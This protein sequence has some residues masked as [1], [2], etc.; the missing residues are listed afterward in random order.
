MEN[1]S[2]AAYKRL[3]SNPSDIVND[4]IVNSS[5]PTIIMDKNYKIIFVNELAVRLYGIPF[6]KIFMKNYFGVFCN[7]EDEY[8]EF[9]EFYA[10]IFKKKEPVF[11]SNKQNN[12]YVRI[13]PILSPNTGEVEYLHN[14]FI[15]DEYHMT[16]EQK[17]DLKLNNDYIQF[18]HQLS[19]LIEAKDKYTAN[20]SS[21]VAKYSALLGKSIGLSGIE[22]EKLKL[23]SSLHD[24]GKVSIP[25]HILNK[26]GK[27]NE[28]EYN[29]IKEHSNYSGRI[30]K[31]FK[32]LGDISDA[33]LYH[34]EMYNGQGYPY[35]IKGRDI[36]L[37]ARIIT[38]TD[39]FD[40]MTT[41]RPY[42]MAVSLNE[43]I[44][45]LKENRATQFD[46]YLVDKFVNLNLSEA[47]NSLNN[48][49]MMRDDE[50][51][52][53]DEVSKLMQQNIY[54]M[55]NNIDPFDI[56][57]NMINHNYYGFIISKDSKDTSENLDDRFE[58]L[59]KS[60]LVDELI[61]NGYLHGNWQM[62]LKEKKNDVCNNCPVDR[63]LSINSMHIKKSKLVNSAGNVKYLKTLLRPEHSKKNNETFILEL[64]KDETL[65]VIYGNNTA[66]EFFNFVDNLSKIFV[67]RDFEYS[68]IYGEIRGLANWIA[69][70]VLISEHK[71]ELLNKALSICDLGIVALLDSNEYIYEN[72]IS[73]RTNKEHIRII[74]NMI[75]NLRTFEDIKDIVL[76]HHIKYNDTKYPLSGDEVP[77]QSYIIGIAD[78]LLTYTVMGRPILEILEYLE[79]ASGITTS[80]LICTSI[81]QESSKN[82]LIEILENV[83]IK[84]F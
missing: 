34:H 69:S 38:V 3:I 53:T 33:G 48:I 58:L 63:C 43:A 76:Y 60:S 39:S 44:N 50:L 84:L 13:F 47:M 11:V 5:Y 41:D 22:L 1:S 64:L 26:T 40:A 23:A 32:S 28:Q 72:L 61:N 68:I 74:Y 25:N 31:V 80:P 79:S 55:F 27:L 56:L 19:V 18:A 17:D 82:E 66:T 51:T 46:P 81:L 10:D 45:E 30:L 77:I 78:F 6:K 65:N 2:F 71:T 16:S 52:A 15:V 62:C 12:S 9:T 21:N 20:H 49:D 37:Y 73:L 7:S 42:K 35:G 59:Y 29:Y 8:E 57:D 14:L 54:D 36:P 70:K 24:I 4:I 67:E 75:T 83:R